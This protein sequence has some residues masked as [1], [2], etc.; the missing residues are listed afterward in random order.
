M[1]TAGRAPRTAGIVLAAGASRRMGRNKMLLDIR[2]ESLIRRVAR[3]VLD[4]GLSPVVVVLGHEEALAKA[5]LTGLAC[6]TTVNPDFT[7]PM[8]GSLHKG[9]E[10]LGSDVEAAVIV[11]ADMPLVTSEML[12][13]VV[14]RAAGSSAPLVVSRY[15]EVTAPPLLFRR[16]LFGELL[17]Y[18]GEG[19]GKAVVKAH[20]SEAL[21]VDRPEGV[22]TDIDTPDDLVAAE[23]LL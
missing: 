22:L 3:R 9:L 5:Q 18:S 15:G 8:S 19:C 14:S 23:Q 12:A 6:E 20:W 7:G 17:A 10:K 1:P 11:L 13:D 16:P 2:G 21:F 4:A